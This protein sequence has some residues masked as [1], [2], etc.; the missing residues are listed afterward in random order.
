MKSI[1]MSF[2]LLACLALCA[3]AAAPKRDLAQER[4]QAALQ[5]LNDDPSLGTLAPAER[6]R[7][8]QAVDALVAAERGEREVLVF[9]AERRL[10]IA[11]AAA[12]AER[13]ATARLER[14]EKALRRALE[15]DGIGA[16]T[17]AGYGRFEA[18]RGL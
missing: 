6:L 10:D 15:E 5:A 16:K 2:P 11:R 13:T 4:L 3:C 8:R 18:F 17:G 9:T 7:A 12:E 14:A 1:T